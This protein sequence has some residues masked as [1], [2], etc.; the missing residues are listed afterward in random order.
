MKYALVIVE[1]PEKIWR[2]DTAVCR[3]F[4]NTALERIGPKGKDTM[5]NPTSFLCN[6]GN[7][8]HDVAILV[9]FA[10]ERGFGSRTLF[11]D[12]DP[13]WVFS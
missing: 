11:F 7:G 2:E 9:G 4:A 5:L 8:L 12:H 1:I 10:K 3:N 6:L 13:S